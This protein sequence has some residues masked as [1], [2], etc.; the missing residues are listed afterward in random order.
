MMPVPVGI[1]FGDLVA[2]VKLLKAAGSA[3]KSSGGAS[4]DYQRTIQQLE[5]RLAVLQTVTQVNDIAGPPECVT[6]IRGLAQSTETEIKKSLDAILSY[7]PH[8]RTG[9]AKN[10]LVTGWKKIKWGTS[11]GRRVGQEVRQIDSDM[12]TAQML[13]DLNISATLAT[14]SSQSA[15]S[16]DLS[17]ARARECSTILALLDNV[18]R[19]VE[20]IER[21]VAPTTQQQPAATRGFDLGAVQLNIGDERPSADLKSSVQTLG[22]S[23][24]AISATVPSHHEL[25]MSRLE[26]IDQNLSPWT[27]P[28]N[29]VDSESLSMVF[30]GTYQLTK[31]LY[32][33][34]VAFTRFLAELFSQLIHSATLTSVYLHLAHAIPLAVSSITSD[35]IQLLDVLGRRHSVPF[36]NLRCWSDFKRMLEGRFRGRPG[37]GKVSAGQF[38]ILNA[39]K[40][41]FILDESTWAE[42]IQ[43]G[44]HLL[45]SI[46]IVKLRRKVQ[47]G[48]CLRQYCLGILRTTRNNGLRCSACGLHCYEEDIRQPKPTEAPLYG[49][50]DFRAEVEKTKEFLR[51]LENRSQRLGKGQP[52][53]SISKLPRISDLM[54]AQELHQCVVE[55]KKRAARREK[56]GWVEPNQAVADLRKRIAEMKQREDKEALDQEALELRVF[57]RIHIRSAVYE[58]SND[59]IEGEDVITEVTYKPPTKPVQNAA[60]RRTLADIV[61]EETS[62]WATTCL[63]SAIREGA[64]VDNIDPCYGT[65]LQASSSKGSIEVSS[66]LLDHGADP[67]RESPAHRNAIHAAALQDHGD[68]LGL[69]LKS[70]HKSLQSCGFEDIEK[71]LMFRDTCDEALRAAT[72][73]GCNKAVLVLLNF[74]DRVHVGTAVC[75]GDDITM[76][77][78]MGEALRLGDVRIGDCIRMLNDGSA[79]MDQLRQFKNDWDYDKGLVFRKMDLHL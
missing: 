40:E 51:R 3:L 22:T 5:K 69:L 63:A 14:L 10:G 9:M 39:R 42:S 54:I 73:R 68:V 17:I 47:R 33:I 60:R 6:A 36:Q 11:E 71:K 79:N 43:P 49:P 46:E 21:L 31:G 74:T 16:L 28:K 7:E 66:F 72:L 67:L 78:I 25:Q 20:A 56:E 53:T 34:L 4:E 59:V 52:S 19:K 30:S 26:H 27:I 65:A 29:A 23:L 24:A 12:L 44:M 18:S 64:D 41:D 62:A 1:G 15:Q 8:L 58:S 2:A 57:L 50:Q 61:M 35:N 76:K 32:K 77:I 38:R 75:S 37:S 13:L 55:S 70:C 45:M 48:S